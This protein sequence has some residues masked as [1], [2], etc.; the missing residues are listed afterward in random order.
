MTDTQTDYRGA[1][2]ETNSVF[3]SRVSVGPRTIRQ[4][5]ELAVE[6][7]DDDSLKG[8]SPEESP[9][10]AEARAMLASLTLCYARQIYRSTDA[11]CVVARDLSFPCLHGGELPD[12]CVLRRFRAENREAIQRCLTAALRFL[13]EQKI[14]S[15]V[16]TKV[17]V[18]QV[19]EEARRRVIIAMFEDSTEQDEDLAEASSA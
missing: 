17:S 13:V 18:P 3:Q 10:F 6:A 14:S 5:I 11:A 12:A 4:A 2:T 8:L 19:A 16:V 9:P 15:G 1:R 7:I